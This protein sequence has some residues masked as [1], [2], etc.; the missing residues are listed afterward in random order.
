MCYTVCQGFPTFLAG[1]PNFFALLL[2]EQKNFPPE[3][4]M[5]FFCSFAIFT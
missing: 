2:G 4:L 3:E 1:G 5:T